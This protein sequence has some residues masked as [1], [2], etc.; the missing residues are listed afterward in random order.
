MKKLLLL[1]LSAIV[2]NSY[3]QFGNALD[4]V[5]SGL[6]GSNYISIPDNGTLD[7]QSTYTIEAWIYERDA[8]NNTIIDKGNYQYLFMG[9]ANGTTELGFYNTGVGAWKYSSGASLTT[10]TWTHVAMTFNSATGD[11][12]FYKNGSYLNTATGAA[13]ATPDNGD[14]NVGRQSPI[15]C[16]C[17]MMDGSMDELRVWNVVRTDAEIAADYN[18]MI[19]NAHSQW[20]NL[21]L[22]YRFDQGNAGS[23]NTTLPNE[24]ID[25]SDNDNIG[26]LQNF[27]KSGSTSNWI[28]ASNDEAPILTTTLGSPGGSVADVYGYIYSAGETTVTTRGFCYSTSNYP[29]TADLTKNA[30][31]SFSTGSYSLQLTDL[32]EG[33][34]YYVRSYAINSKGT[35]YG[36]TKSF[37]AKTGSGSAI[38]FDGND[39]ITVPN[40]TSTTPGTALTFESWIYISSNLMG[41]IVM[42]GDYGWGVIIGADGC[43]SGNKLN[44]WVNGGCGSSIASTGTIPL[45]QWTHIAVVVTTSPSQSLQFYINGMDAGSSTSGSITINN[46]NNN[47]LFIG[48]QGYCYC[49]YF[50]GQMD[51]VRLWNAALTQTQVRDWMCKKVNYS[52]PQYSNLGAYFRGDEGSGS[53]IYDDANQNIGTLAGNSFTTSSAPVGD[54]ASWLTTVSN[55]STINVAGDNG[56]DIT[57]EVTSGS[58]ELMVVYRVDERPNVTTAPGTLQNLSGENYFGVKLL[59]SSSGVYKV[60][61]NYDGHPGITD[62][63]QLGFASRASNA[64]GSWTEETGAVLNTGANTILLTG[65]T[66]TEFIMGSKTATPLPVELLEFNATVLKNEVVLSW[67]TASEINNDYFLLQRSNDGITWIQNARITGAMNSN[68]IVY[69]SSSDKN[70][71]PGI[72]YYRLAQVDNNGETHYSPT[73]SVNFGT[74]EK[75]NLIVY[76]NPSEGMVNLVGSI[77]QLQN[78]KVYNSFGQEVSV[79][80]K[81]LNSNENQLLIDISSLPQGLYFIRSKTN[82]AKVQKQ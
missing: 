51:E 53:S 20:S 21:K 7:L 6:G 82:S 69:Y 17:N 45:N 23:G 15:G 9:H 28:S 54:D 5:G 37:V 62:E 75:T 25:Y 46:G 29:T 18:K 13:N 48:T 78:I 58:A 71:L 67:A 49:N 50:N 43:S 26:T 73:L 40:S 38:T 36:E 34:R 2:V 80:V 24:V 72:S 30:T 70:P 47:P 11:I 14:V 19:T 44:Y 31:G 61:Y 77:D 22:Y 63:S 12:K 68:T 32:T 55:G 59:G 76:P 42:K 74:E 41:N 52:H 27:T 1:I 64:T 56:D 66:G 10:N 8:S 4:F 35:S 79:Q 57:A 33:T 3:A 60:T 16:L 65:Q 81:A 39:Y